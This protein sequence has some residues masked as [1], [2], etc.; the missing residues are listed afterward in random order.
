MFDHV[1]GIFDSGLVPVGGVFVHL[2]D[3]IGDYTYFCVIPHEA[4]GLIRVVD[5]NAPSETDPFMLQISDTSIMKVA[6]SDGSIIA[7][8]VSSVPQTG[9]T[10]PI[11]IFFTGKFGEPLSDVNYA[12]IA[13]QDN[14]L[15]PLEYDDR[16][17]DGKI[18]YNVGPM[19]SNNTLVI[20]LRLL[21]IGHPNEISYITV[22]SGELITLQVK[23]IMQEQLSVS[24]IRDSDIPKWF[25]TVLSWYDENLITEKEVLD[26]FKFL[27]EKKIIRN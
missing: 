12:I 2:F 16:Q 9:T 25:R 17:P 7:S 18:D 4:H 19:V 5:R 21:G 13:L 24:Q 8:L 11:Q 26:G 1:D 6:S 20:Q 10:I 3:K 15:I 27:I 22:A 14:K 23:G